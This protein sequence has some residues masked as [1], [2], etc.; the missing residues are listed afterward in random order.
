MANLS[1]PPSPVSTSSGLNPSSPL[2]LYQLEQLKMLQRNHNLPDLSLL[3][4]NPTVFYTAN[5]FWWQQLIFSLP[6]VFGN[7]IKQEK[8]TE[9]SLLSIKNEMPNRDYILTPETPERE[10]NYD[11]DIDEPLNL[12]KKDLIHR[13][14]DISSS[15]SMPPTP[16]INSNLFSAIWSPASLVSQN[17]KSY[18]IKSESIENSPTTPKLKF[19]FDNL[20]GLSLKR[21]A[22]SSIDYET[23]KKNCTDMFLINNNNNNLSFNN[24]NLNTSFS[25]SDSSNILDKVPKTSRKSLPIIKPDSTEHSDFLVH[26]FRDERGKKERSFEVSYGNNCVKLIIT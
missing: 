11:I 12:S 8:K 20:R 26:E 16:K 6:P 21:E 14:T 15:L 9:M 4:Q 23:L 24:N 1:S 3:Y 25:G 10:E 2:Y 18:A 17:E 13:D 5:P 19:N 7:N 22:P